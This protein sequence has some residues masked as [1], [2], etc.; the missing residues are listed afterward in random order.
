MVYFSNFLVV[1]VF[2]FELSDNLSGKNRHEYH[3][4]V[5]YFPMRFESLLSVDQIQLA[6]KSQEIKATFKLEKF[7]FIKFV[8][9]VLD[10]I[11][12]DLFSD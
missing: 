8:Y 2:P 7:I 4:D 12:M 11:T 5:P 10:S 9:F 6:V 1:G 3:L